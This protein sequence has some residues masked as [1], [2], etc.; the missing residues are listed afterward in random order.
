MVGIVVDECVIR[1]AVEGKK[2][3]GG[4]AHAEAEFVHKLLR[5]TGTIFVNCAIA[6]KFRS[7]EKKIRADSRPEHCNNAI[8]K[9]FVAVLRDSSRTTYA[10]G[11]DVDWEGLKKCDR[12]FVGVALQSGSTL[13]TSDK[14]LRD[15]AR[16]KRS[17][18]SRIACVAAGDALGLLD[19]P[20][21]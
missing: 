13:V 6:A 20:H 1:E 18:G 9:D 8:Y 11:I 17:Q 4:R 5:S 14:K 2:P 19:P 21:G 3:G 16:E 15:I 12:E 7:L 10:D